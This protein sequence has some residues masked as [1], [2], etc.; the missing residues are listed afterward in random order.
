[1][2]NVVNRTQPYSM[3]EQPG[4]PGRVFLAR[5]FEHYCLIHWGI[6][7]GEIAAEL[8]CTDRP[9]TASDVRGAARMLGGA[10]ARD[11]VPTWAR[12]FGGGEPVRLKASFWELDAFDRRFTTCAIDPAKPFEPEAV[13]THWI[14]VDLAA[15]N[16]L[17]E[18]S[19]G[20]P[21]GRAVPMAENAPCP[22]QGNAVGTV[23]RTDRLV[24][25]PEVRDRTGLSRSTIY[26]RMEQGTFPKSVSLTGNV[27]V[28]QES[29]L[30]AWLADPR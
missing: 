27:T 8:L 23:D 24:R 26:R 20:I 19:L 1:M 7:R 15:W 5:A 18:A 3:L 17:I 22:S 16:D 30:R 21:P 6:D 4:S 25:F 13:P 29:D 28:W 2:M 9:V 14:F 12:A 10:F 11:V